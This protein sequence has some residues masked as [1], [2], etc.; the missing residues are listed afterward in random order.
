MRLHFKHVAIKRWSMIVKY[1]LYK[2]ELPGVFLK[3]HQHHIG[4]LPCRTLCTRLH[5]WAWRNSCNQPCRWGWTL[6]FRAWSVERWHRTLKV[7]RYMN[8]KCVLVSKHCLFMREWNVCAHSRSIDRRVW[9]LM[10]T[11]ARPICYFNKMCVLRRRATNTCLLI[12]VPNEAVCSHLSNA[13]IQ[14]YPLIRFDP[15]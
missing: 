4:G 5:R 9:Q 11:Q 1:L 13:M 10:S 8:V 15:R 12:F 2:M 6:P 7:M 3:L 14:M